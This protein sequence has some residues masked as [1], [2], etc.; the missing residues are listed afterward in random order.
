MPK[1]IENETIYRAAMQAVMERG[2]AGATTKQI[3]EAARISEVTLFRKYDNK[4]QLIKQAI[5]EMAR[6][7]DFEA[8][9]RYTGNVADDLLRVVQT[10]QDSADKHGQF[11]YMM[12]SEIPRHPE[13][14]DL[15]DTPFDMVNH[16]GELLGRYQAEGVLKQEHPLH[17]V[18][19]LLGPV[20][21]TNMIRNARADSPLPP[22]DLE[23]H[24]THFLNGRIQLQ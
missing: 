14:G 12:L 17:A 21:S 1:I 22:N 23:T 3:A 18:A 13:L 4:A 20:I 7:F 8:A 2:Y 6:Q 15:L 16:I 11:F 24:V 5:A 9:S 10:Y 19:G